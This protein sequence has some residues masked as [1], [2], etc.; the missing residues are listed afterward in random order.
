MRP[1]KT[2]SLTTATVA[3][4]TFLLAAGLELML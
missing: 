4:T 2:F 1:V 3:V